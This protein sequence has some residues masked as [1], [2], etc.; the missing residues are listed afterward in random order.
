MSTTMP[1]VIT[2][3]PLTA[4]CLQS[5]NLQHDCV[6]CVVPSLNTFTLWH[7]I[8][9]NPGHIELL[10]VPMDQYIFAEI[11]ERLY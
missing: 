3:V 8:D 5:Q 11:V 4:L 7:I 6:M 9:V 10:Q 1:I 2:D